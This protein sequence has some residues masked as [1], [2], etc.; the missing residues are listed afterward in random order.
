MMQAHDLANCHGLQH[1]DARWMQSDTH[2]DIR[3]VSYP[4]PRIVAGKDEVC[5]AMIGWTVCVSI[6]LFPLCVQLY[7]TP[8]WLCTGCCDLRLA[9][10]LLLHRHALP[11]QQLLP[12]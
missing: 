3:R 8:G 7:T 5:I 9:I 6:P 4:S 10:A 11:E 2:T 1:Y 12:I